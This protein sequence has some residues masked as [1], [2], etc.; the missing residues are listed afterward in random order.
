MKNADEGATPAPPPDSGSCLADPSRPR[1]HHW[2]WM[3]V[4]GVMSNRVRCT[5]CGE[6]K[7][8]GK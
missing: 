3:W 1:A 4:D 5:R 6:T 8:N 7:E 2:Q